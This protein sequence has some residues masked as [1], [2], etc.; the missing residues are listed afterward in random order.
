MYDPR[1]DKP[2]FAAHPSQVR[3]NKAVRNQVEMVMRDLDSTLPGDHPVRAIWAFLER[4]D[5]SAFYASIEAVEGEPGR[6][7]TDPQVLLALWVYATAE[8]IG[9]AR[10]LER[11][12]EEHDAFRWL[13][14]G[15]PIN[16]HMLADFRVTHGEALD[17][18][19]SEILTA[20]MAADLVTLKRVSQDGKR[21]RADDGAASFRRESSL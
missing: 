8:G 12:C 21:A 6:P 14:G 17:K 11:L 18:L 20:M 19:L 3:V 10:H 5:L 16:Y 9:S 7:A 4:L 1:E 2:G 13:R 15:V